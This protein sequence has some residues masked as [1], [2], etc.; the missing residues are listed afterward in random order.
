MKIFAVCNAH[1]HYAFAEMSLKRWIKDNW[2]LQAQTKE[3][4]IGFILPLYSVEKGKP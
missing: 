3:L 4:E 1:L 2:S